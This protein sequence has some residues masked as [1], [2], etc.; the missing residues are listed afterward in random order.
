MESIIDIIVEKS[1]QK[2]LVTCAEVSHWSKSSHDFHQRLYK[3]LYTVGFLTFSSERLGFIDAMLMN[4]WLDGLIP[5]SLESLYKDVLL[6][7]GLGTYRIMEFFKSLR[8]KNKPFKLIG[9]EVDVLSQ[10]KSKTIIYLKSLLTEKYGHSLDFKNIKKIGTPVSRIDKQFSKYLTIA[11]QDK[12]NNPYIESAEPWKYRYKI[13]YSVLQKNDKLFV[14]GFHLSKNELLHLKIPML[15]IGM[16]SYKKELAGY[17]VT[18]LLNDNKLTINNIADKKSSNFWDLFR[19]IVSQ[20]KSWKKNTIRYDKYYE[21]SS[22]ERKYINKF[23]LMSP[24]S[25]D[26]ITQYGAQAIP[27][28]KSKVIKSISGRAISDYDLVVFIPTSKFDIRMYY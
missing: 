18:N 7:G 17:D 10:A 25:K 13:W 28:V 19:D 8:S 5:V 14:N 2:Q 3:K 23:A 20:N 12:R 22:I 26:Y 1:K 16:A 6:F 11:S 27:Y 4:A 21:G 24:N 15:C 9:C